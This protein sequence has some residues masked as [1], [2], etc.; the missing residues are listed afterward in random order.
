M[1]TLR[2]SLWLNCVNVQLLSF[3]YKYSCEMLPAN[4]NVMFACHSDISSHEV[5]YRDCYHVRTT[6]LNLTQQSLTYHA[7]L[8]WNKS[9]S[10]IR[11]ST[12][13]NSS[14]FGATFASPASVTSFSLP[15]NLPS[16]ASLLQLSNLK[17]AGNQFHS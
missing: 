3:I 10:E 13:L 16:V 8:L 7:P 11:N 14:N 4:Y 5:R 17:V 1:H 6:I 15:N 2:L 12:I 9:D